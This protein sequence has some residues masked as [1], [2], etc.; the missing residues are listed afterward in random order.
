MIRQVPPVT[1]TEITDPDEV[2]RAR[3]RRAKFDRNVAW[4]EAHAAEAYSHRGK[5]ICIA[6]EELFVGDTAR[7]VRTKA[8]AAHPDDEGMFTRFIP[9]SRAPRIYAR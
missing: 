1:I 4:L 9:L 7:E 6:G 3:A 5:Y 2:A 8:R